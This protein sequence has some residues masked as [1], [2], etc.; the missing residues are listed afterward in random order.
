MLIGIITVLSF[1]LS[2]V[3]LGF[4]K[5]ASNR[6]EV[7]EHPPKPDREIPASTDS[8][9]PTGPAR[10][11]ADLDRATDLRERLRHFDRATCI[12][13]SR[14]QAP[15]C[16]DVHL[17]GHPAIR[18]SAKVKVNALTMVEYL[19]AEKAAVVAELHEQGYTV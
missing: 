13:R 14:G 11:L 12:A 6:V 5:S 19:E 1:A 16:V 8:T 10:Q 2:V 17:A 9:Y 7:L 4:A 18:D 3:A 15:L